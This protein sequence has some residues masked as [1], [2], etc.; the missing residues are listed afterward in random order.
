MT[1]EEIRAEVDTFMFE[2]HDT[3]A[4][5]ISWTLYNLSIHPE[6]QAKC[7]DE[8][9]AFFDSLDSETVT[10]CV[11]ICLC[12]VHISA[13]TDHSCLFA[14]CTSHSHSY[15]TQLSSLFRDDIS[16]D[17]CLEYLTMCLKESMRMHPPVS[18]L[19]RCLT[20]ETTFDGRKMPAGT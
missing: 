5:G 17:N 8:V 19:A 9:D 3:T 6:H 20:K 11:L 10:W 18:A 1:D 14:I 7:H 15:S 13:Q 16:G 12:I 4:S 2:G